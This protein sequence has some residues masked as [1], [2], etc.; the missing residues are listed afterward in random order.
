M[1]SPANRHAHTPRARLTQ[2]GETGTQTTHPRLRQKRRNLPTSHEVS[3]G[4]LCVRVENGVPYVA[5]IARRTRSGLLEWCLPK[6]HL[7]GDETPAQAA[8]REVQEETGIKGQIICHVCTVDYW[9]SGQ[10]VRVHKKVHHYLMEYVS[11]VI[12][13][14]NDPDH[15]AEQ[16]QWIDLRQVP[17]ILAYPNERRVAKTAYDL[18]YPDRPMP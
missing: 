3:A 11:G 15:E 4:G 12:T 16:A 6:G 9:F 13:V 14:D 1:S 17:S 2:L 10:D 7:E 18:L 5:V 8:L